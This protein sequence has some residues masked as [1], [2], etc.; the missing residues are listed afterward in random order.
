[1]VY[2]EPESDDHAWTYWFDAGFMEGM[3]VS[4]GTGRRRA[5]EA[6][7]LDC[8]PPTFGQG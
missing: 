5:A 8:I 6:G 3:V 7:E 2:R 4:K 1:M